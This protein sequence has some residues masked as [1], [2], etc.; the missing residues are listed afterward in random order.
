AA[1]AEAKR[2]AEEEKRLAAEALAKRI[3]DDSQPARPT[4]T[5]A[6][7]G[8]LA[9]GAVRPGTPCADAPSIS[10]EPLPGGRTRILVSAPCRAGETVTVWYGPFSFIRKLDTSGR[11]D[12]PLDLFMGEGVITRVGFAGGSEERIVPRA[13][14]IAQVS[15]I[16]VIWKAPVNLDLHAFEYLA[17]PGGRGH[18][19]AGAPS[20]GEKAKAEAIGGKLARGFLSSAADATTLGDKV[21]VYTL[22]NVPGQ[23]S[24]VVST[25]IDFE[26]RGEMPSGDTCGNGKLARANYRLLLFANNQIIGDEQRALAPAACGEALSREVRFN[27]D[28]SMSLIVRRQ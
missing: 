4:T 10:T 8:T 12:Y 11:L 20:S 3:A 19:W 28:T 14:D 5:A 25:V 13:D 17:R 24:G 15:K 1:E 21:E 22:W 6:V 9:P 7:S 23:E 26:T 18:V 2:K 16:A 27:P